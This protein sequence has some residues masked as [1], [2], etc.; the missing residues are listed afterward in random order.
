MRTSFGQAAT[1]CLLERSMAL[2]NVQF[3]TFCTLF[4]KII[5]FSKTNLMNL[6]LIVHRLD[7]ALRDLFTCLNCLKKQYSCFSENSFLSF[8][9]LKNFRD[10]SRKLLA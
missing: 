3:L 2:E 5:H 8:F 6:L 10:F 4:E 9:F 1:P 7:F